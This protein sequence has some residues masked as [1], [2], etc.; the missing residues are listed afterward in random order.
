MKV[1][2]EFTIDI[3]QD[4]WQQ[5]YGIAREDVREDVKTY[6][7]NGSMDHLR[8]M[9]LLVRAQPPKPDGWGGWTS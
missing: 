5:E 9:G 8:E 1:K 7:I 6:V 2:I 3:D 4:T